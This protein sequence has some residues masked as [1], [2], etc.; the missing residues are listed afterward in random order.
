MRIWVDSNR[1]MLSIIIVNFKNPPL[2]RLCLKSLMNVLGQDFPWE[3]IVVDVA[4]SIE[5]RNIISEF[6]KVNSICFKDNIGYTKGV[7]EGIKK[8]SGN[9][10]LILNADIIPLK[11]SI[12]KMYDYLRKN[13]EIG[14]IGPQLLNFDGT[15]Q[16]SC[17]RFSSPLTLVY[18]RTFLGRL[19]F[20]RRHLNNFTMKDAN[21]LDAHPADWLMG[22]ALMVNKE[23]VNK[24]GLMDEN[25]FL[26]MSDIDWPSRFWENGYTV[27]YYPDSKMYHY[28]KRDSKGRFGVLD[29]LFK[30]ESRW[31]LIDAIKYFRKHGISAKSFS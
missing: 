11:N 13:S 17:F 16:N 1:L 25:M 7:N 8:S 26:Y 31:H 24:V 6:P 29:I 5:T 3:I 28:H 15:P 18:R 19:F 4:S 10:M 14:I 27:I 2:L 12:E 30:K 23:A 22:S 20:G 21:G 9:A